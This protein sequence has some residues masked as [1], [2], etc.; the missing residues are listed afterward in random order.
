MLMQMVGSFAECERAMLRERTQAGRVV[1]RVRGRIGG[2]RPKLGPSPQA[3]MV[4]LVQAGWRSQAEAAR[5][6]RGHPGSGSQRRP[7]LLSM[8]NG[9]CCRALDGGR[10]CQ[11]MAP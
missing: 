6:F 1:A 5:L 3:E 10:S 7:G 2:R 9:R 8:D 4:D 11:G